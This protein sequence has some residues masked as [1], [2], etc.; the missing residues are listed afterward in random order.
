MRTRKLPA[1]IVARLRRADGFTL[2]ELIAVMAI[3][4]TVMT[5]LVASFVTGIN[6]EVDQTR[7]EQAYANGRLAI[8]RLRLDIHCASGV[9]AVDQNAYGGFTLTLTESNDQSPGGWCPGVIPAGSTSSGVQWCTI[10]YSGSTTRFVLYRFLG[11]N[12]TDCNGGSG[13]TFEVDYIAATPGVW[14][15]NSSVVPAPTSWV[16]NLWPD[17]AACPTGNLPTVA[18]D[19]NVAVDPVTHPSEHYQLRD[20][21]ALR[22]ANRC[23]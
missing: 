5:A 19:L 9:T 2:I 4:G 23:P 15:T 17:A 13:S 18:I 22:N 11:L 14:P 16:G 1:K 21:I 20:A 12:P 7:R 3:L 6:Q 8:Q 10:P